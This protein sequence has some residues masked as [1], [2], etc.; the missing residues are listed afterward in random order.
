MND[1][2]KNRPH[3]GPQGGPPGRGPMKTEV[4]AQGNDIY[5]ITG[6]VHQYLIVG[7]EKALLIDTGMGTGRIRPLIEQVTK[8]PIVL[9]NTHGH[10]DHAGGNA[11]FDTPAYMC[12]DDFDVFEKMATKEFRLDE[13]SAHRSREEVEKELQPTAQHP[14]AIEDGAVIDLGGRTVKVIYTP[15]HTHGSLSVY[16]EETGYMFVG[17]NAMSRRTSLHEWCSSPLSVFISSLEKIKSYGP[18]RLYSGH[19]PKYSEPELLDRLIA[20]AGEILN[21]AQGELDNIRGTEAYV[22]GLISYVE[23]KVN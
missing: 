10:P 11:E 22:Y 8:L 21:G 15:G 23:D 17:D 9:I 13:L 1:E 7:K 19:D 18:V 2:M 14:V 6:M 3:H 12:P 20:C 16:D 5:D 4:V